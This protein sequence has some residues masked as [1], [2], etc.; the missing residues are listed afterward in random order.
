MF[1]NAIDVERNLR[2][3]SIRYKGVNQVQRGMIQGHI[4][5]TIQDFEDNVIYLGFL[6]KPYNYNN[7]D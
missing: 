3:S 2:K 5:Y 6:L 4:P 7:K 1:C